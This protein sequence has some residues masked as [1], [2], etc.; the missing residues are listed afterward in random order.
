MSLLLLLL[1]F[2]STNGWTFFRYSS[3]QQNIHF[4]LK[5]HSTFLQVTSTLDADNTSS[6][7][8]TSN[9]NKKD[10]ETNDNDDDDTDF[11]YVEYE[12]LAEIDFIGSEWLVGT[13]F[14]QRPNVIQETWVRL[15][16]DETSGKNKCVWGDN[17]EGVWSVDA[18]SQYVSMSKN[19]LWGKTI[20]AGV[21]EDYYFLQGT[22]R[23]WTYVSAAEVVGQWQSRRLGIEPEEA[24][25]APWFDTDVDVDN[26]ESMSSTTASPTDT[27]SE[28]NTVIVDEK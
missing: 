3:F 18:A 27:I 11:E 26:D 2:I 24:G 13:N 1:S 25:V 7:I 22:V 23:A 19:Y 5:R 4:P 17:S 21:A 15:I 6:S 28:T 16:Q 8:N 10:K 12:R 14:N 20:W 9:S